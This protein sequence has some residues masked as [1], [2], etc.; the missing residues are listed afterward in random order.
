MENVNVETMINDLVN[1]ATR[2]LSEFERLT[3]E[4]VDYI[5][6]KCSIS[7]IDQHGSLA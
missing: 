6:A 1:N 3:Q 4:Q 2:A 5:V 7:A